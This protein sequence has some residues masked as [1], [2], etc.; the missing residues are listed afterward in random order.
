MAESLSD[1]EIPEIALKKLAVIREPRIF[2]FN[3][4]Y[5]AMKRYSV[6][7]SQI[8]L[9]I[10]KYLP[11]KIN[12]HCSPEIFEEKLRKILHCKHIL[13][14]AQEF[15][16]GEGPTHLVYFFFLINICQKFKIM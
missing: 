11:T 15:S 8:H 14:I 1:W 12:L 9:S 5:I 4:F 2:G 7:P 10:M 16:V 13:E 6:L 3:C